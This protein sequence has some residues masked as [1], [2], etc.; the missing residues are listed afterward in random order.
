VIRIEMNANVE[1]RRGRDR[2][3]KIWIGCVRQDMGEM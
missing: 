2:P 1:G 3:R